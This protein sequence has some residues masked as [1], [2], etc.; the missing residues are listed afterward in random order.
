MVAGADRNSKVTLRD[1]ESGMTTPVPLRCS[2]RAGF[3]LAVLRKVLDLGPPRGLVGVGLGVADLR[4]R[5]RE[6]ED[7]SGPWVGVVTV[8]EVHAGT[9]LKARR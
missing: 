6:V 8:R 3:S 5:R 1:P 2:A 9:L 4:R 7:P